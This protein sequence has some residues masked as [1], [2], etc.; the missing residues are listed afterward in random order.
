MWTEMNN[1]IKMH[2]TGCRIASGQVPSEHS[3]QPLSSLSSTLYITNVAAGIAQQ[4]IQT[5]VTKSRLHIQI[6]DK[7]LRHDK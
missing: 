2:E 4:E 1:N 5:K 3:N 7:L 6:L